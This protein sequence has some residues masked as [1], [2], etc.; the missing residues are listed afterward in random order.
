MPQMRCISMVSTAH[1]GGRA[2]DAEEGKLALEVVGDELAAVV[3]AQLQAIRDAL[4]EGAET[5]A[6][7]LAQRLERLETRRAAGSVDAQAL[8]RGVI[9]GDEDRGLA[10]AGQGRG[11]IGAPHLVDPLGADGAVVGLRAVPSPD[12]AGCEQVMVAHQP[13]DAALGG[14]DT[15]E[16]QPRPDFP[17]AFTMEQPRGQQFADRRD[18]RRVRHGPDRTRP[19]PWARRVVPPMTIQ[20]GPRRELDFGLS[21]TRELEKLIVSR[22]LAHG[23][24]PV[25]RWMAS[26][27]AVAQDPAGNLRPAK[28][29]STKRIDGIVALIM[30]IG[31]AMLPSEQPRHSVY[32]DR[33]ILVL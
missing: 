27:V 19:S 11:R 3:V 17:V 10:L 4:A 18:Q 14:A 15:G 26:N 33:G 9:D 32:E 7:G 24:N 1:E 12:P 31:R 22:K 29:K 23:G 16:A 6:H 25:T 5:G 21:V 30:A 2:C 8:G 28:D 20:R 13:Q